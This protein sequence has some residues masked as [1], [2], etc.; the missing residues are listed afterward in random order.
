MNK[1]AKIQTNPKILLSSTMETNA[2]QY[3][4]VRNIPSCIGKF[5]A[6]L[7]PIPIITECLFVCACLISEQLNH[8]NGK[9]Y[10]TGFFR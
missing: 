2:M 1:V 10:G 8:E 5:S 7:H 3:A 4:Q 6:Y 9:S